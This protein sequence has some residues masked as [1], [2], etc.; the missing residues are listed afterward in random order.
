M[1]HDDWSVVCPLIQAHKASKQKPAPV[2]PP[3]K[4]PQD[5]L[6]EIVIAAGWN[7]D[8]FAPFAVENG[9]AT[10]NATEFADIATAKASALVKDADALRAQIAAQKEGGGK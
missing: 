8:Q 3:E 9:F 6:A 4:T 1:V 10:E 7:W 2:P 5:K